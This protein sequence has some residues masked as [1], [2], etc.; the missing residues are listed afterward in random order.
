MLGAD[1]EVDG[2]AARRQLLLHLPERA[3]EVG[4]LAVEHVDEEDAG[5]PEL[6]GPLPDP[7]R[8][9]ST[10]M[11]PLRTTSALDDAQRAA[12]L[13]LEARIAGDVDQVELAALPLGVRERERDRHPPL[14]LVVVPVR[15]GRAGFDRPEPVR[16]AHLE[17]QCLDE[18]GLAGAAV[19]DD[20]DVADL[21]RLE[22]GHAGAPPRLVG[23][24]GS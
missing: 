6:L 20:G 24:G 22:S 12:G 2:D 1:R 23:L 16:L 9:T 8:P 3:E 21:S 11:T 19:T 7:R 14:L 10:P 13:A 18:R 5:D 15:H 4:A 17:E